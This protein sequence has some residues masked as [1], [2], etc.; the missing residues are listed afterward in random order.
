MVLLKKNMEVFFMP[1]MKNKNKNPGRLC[2]S[3][4]SFPGVCSYY[5]ILV[6]VPQGKGLTI[7]TTGGTAAAYR[8]IYN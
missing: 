3:Q 4:P 1:R 8:M 6:G 5:H 2:N 7:N